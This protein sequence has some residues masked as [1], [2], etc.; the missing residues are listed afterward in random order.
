[1]DV[2]PTVISGTDWVGIGSPLRN[3]DD[4]ILFDSNKF[5]SHDDIFVSNNFNT[6]KVKYLKIYARIKP[7]L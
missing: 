3:Y 7:I 4:E 2:A 1:M 6:L 5:M